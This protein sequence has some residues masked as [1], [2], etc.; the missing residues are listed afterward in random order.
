MILALCGYSGG[1]W[2]VGGFDY[3]FTLVS[4]VWG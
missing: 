3:L 4:V 2:G 1:V